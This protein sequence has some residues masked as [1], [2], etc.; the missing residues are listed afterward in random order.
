MATIVKLS[1]LS[2]LKKRL[3]TALKDNSGGVDT[4]KY[5]GVIKL[6]EDAVLI[7]KKLRNEWE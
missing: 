3:N 2:T 1:A 4:K 7:Q 6:K 5:S